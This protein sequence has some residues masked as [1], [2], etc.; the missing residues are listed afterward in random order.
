MGNN[1]TKNAAK[2]VQEIDKKRNEILTII[3]VKRNFRE[4]GK[5][6]NSTVLDTPNF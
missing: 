3:K 5:I 6:A 2:T 4:I 1:L